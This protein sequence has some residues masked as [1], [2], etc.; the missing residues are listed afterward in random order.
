MMNE[1]FDEYGQLQIQKGVRNENHVWF[2]AQFEALNK[3]LQLY[4]Y[5]EIPPYFLH[6]LTYVNNKD[7]ED[8]FRNYIGEHGEHFSLD[9]MFGLYLLYKT[10]G[11]KYYYVNDYGRHKKL[12]ISHWNGEWHLHPNTWMVHLCLHY[13]ILKILFMPFIFLMALVSASRDS[14]KTST[15]ILWYWR[16]RALGFE[17]EFFWLDMN[18]IYQ[19]YFS[20][21]GRFDNE[22]MPLRVLSKEKWR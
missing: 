5:D 19:Y 14:S 8:W 7:G 9:E 2:R 22:D 12:P 3:E 1:Y 6:K 20:G 16:L 10:R 4:K 15:K 13:P 11:M 17:T 18:E 21:A